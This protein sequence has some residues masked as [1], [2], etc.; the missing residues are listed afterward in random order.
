MLVPEPDAEL[1]VAGIL[2]GD[3]VLLVVAGALNGDA[4]VFGAANGGA[5]VE[6]VPNGAAF[7]PAVNG[8]NGAGAV[9][10]G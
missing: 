10:T 5:A 4:V 1:D 2:N 7:A 8:L 6:G 3:A 9:E